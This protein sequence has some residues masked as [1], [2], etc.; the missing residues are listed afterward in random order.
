VISIIDNQMGNIKSVSNALKY[1]NVEHIITQ[2]PSD[3]ALSDGII[4][5]G[6]GS[7]S[8]AAIRLR[9]SGFYEEI[10]LYCASNKPFLG[11]C[12]GMQLLFDSGVEG[13]GTSGLQLI[14]GHVSNLINRVQKLPLPHIGWNEL[15]VKTSKILNG[16]N[17]GD[18]LYFVHGFEVITDEQYIVAKTDYGVDIVA[19]V[20]KN[21][22]FGVQ[23]HPEKS[24]EVGLEILSSFAKL[25]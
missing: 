9:D 13:G 11:I 18:C 20:E 23:F 2:D 7:F 17:N 5:P 21:N 14:P 19:A 22:I 6:V 24:Q 8:Q 12:L 15:T 4:L 25:C 10:Q 16:V 3:I 1:L